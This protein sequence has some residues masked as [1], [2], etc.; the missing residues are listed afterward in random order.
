MGKI[1]GD[2][3][4]TIRKDRKTGVEIFMYKDTPGV[5]LNAYGVEV[6][7]KLAKIAGFPVEELLVQR[8]KR[9]AVDSAMAKIE[10]KFASGA[11][12]VKVVREKDGY[13]VV[14]HG[15]GRFSVRGPDDTKM[16][17]ARKYLTAAE[18][19]MLFKEFVG[20]LPVGRPKAEAEAEAEA[21]EGEGEGG[22]TE[23]ETKDG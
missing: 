14:D 6:S 15:L 2:R 9:E 10:A 19:D 13:K 1:D 5:F 18:A 20:P 16:H 23:E 4:V 22:E 12:E 17:D 7:P 21:D 11:G 8:K 3:G